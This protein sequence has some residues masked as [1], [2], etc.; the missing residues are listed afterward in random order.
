MSMASEAG[1]HL[2]SSAKR[3][4]AE[5]EAMFCIGVDIGGIFM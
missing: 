1:Y 5:L 2:S 3:P 4:R